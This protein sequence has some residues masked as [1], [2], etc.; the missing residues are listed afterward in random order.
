MVTIKNL[1]KTFWIKN[2]PARTVVD[3]LNN[4]FRRSN[5]VS[6][7]HVLQ[8]ID[9]DIKAGEFISFIGRNGSGK[10]TLLKLIAGIYA[11]DKGSELTVNGKIVPFLELGVGFS[12]EFTGRENILLN[13]TILGMTRRFL[14]DHMQ[15]IIDFAELD[16]FIDTP[17]KNYSSGMLVRLAF[18]IAIKADADI[19]LLDEILA[20]GDEAF[21]RKSIDVINSLKAQGK[22]IIFVSHALEL[23][24][25]FSDRVCYIRDG[26]IAKLGS[27]SD[28]IAAYRTDIDTDLSNMWEGTSLSQKL[29]WGDGKA[30]ISKVE[31]KNLFNQD[32]MVD[33]SVH[34]ENP[35]RLKL[36]FGVA[37]HNSSEQIVFGTN[38]HLAGINLPE[39]TEF[40]VRYKLPAK[41]LTDGR[42]ELSTALSSESTGNVYDFHHRHYSFV[43]SNSAKNIGVA[44]FPG[45][46]YV[47]PRGV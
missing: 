25:R 13:G 39:S 6:P 38:T 27:P 31:I 7:Y 47:E 11:P 19:F 34:V 40:I 18:S 10:S 37:I 22:T 14:L 1:N 12:P 32:D 20:V 4:L 29:R 24:E 33:V 21:Q 16:K 8:N 9:L 42:Y 43:V 41:F 28:T 35:F 3:R 2:Q 23:V 17:V 46:W 26:K 36:D 30:K 45:D 44:N 5:N 15:E